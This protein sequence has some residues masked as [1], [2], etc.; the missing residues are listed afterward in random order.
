MP[1]VGHGISEAVEE[2][3]AEGRSW[4]LEGPA[5]HMRDSDFYP[6]GNP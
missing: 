5:G 1:D 6:M 4:A 3:R 2:T